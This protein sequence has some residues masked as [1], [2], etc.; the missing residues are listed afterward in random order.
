MKSEKVLR[1][2]PTTVTVDDHIVHMQYDRMCAN[3]DHIVHTSVT[4]PSGT[5]TKN[6][7]GVACIIEPYSDR[8]AREAIH[9]GY[10]SQVLG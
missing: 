5:V 10:R 8:M 4:A 2:S 6:T 1:E 3:G 9:P 7:L